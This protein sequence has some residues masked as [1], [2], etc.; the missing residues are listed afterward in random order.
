M[1]TSLFAAKTS[2]ERNKKASIITQT[3]YVE[4]V[5][6]ALPADVTAIFP[7]QSSFC[8]ERRHGETPLALKVHMEMSDSSFTKSF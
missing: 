1:K 6:T 5:S 7:A 3:A 2:S 8:L 4:V